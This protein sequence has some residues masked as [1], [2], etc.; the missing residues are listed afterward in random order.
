MERLASNTEWKVVMGFILADTWKSLLK[1]SLQLILSALVHLF[2]P[3]NIDGS[4]IV[5]N[6][7]MNQKLGDL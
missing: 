3:L 1:C 2:V 5:K 6:N 7:P 4:L